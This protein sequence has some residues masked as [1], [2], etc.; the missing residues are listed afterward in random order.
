M[1]KKFE[2]LLD[3]LVNEEM[4]KASQLFH[5][6]VVEKSRDIYESLIA[7]DEDSDMEE[8]F[9]SMA[10]GDESDDLVNDVE[11]DHPSNFEFGMGDQGSDEGD[12]IDGDFGDDD[13]FGTDGSSPATKDDVSDLSDALE[14]LKAE[15]QAL[16]AG[17]KH[18]E[19]GEPDVHGGEL[20]GM[21]DD[22]GDFGSDEGDDID[23]PFDDEG[24]EDEGDEDDEDAEE[25]AATEAFMREYREIVGKPYSGGKVA[26][27]SEESNT[28]SRSV[29]STAKGRPTTSATAGNLLQ[30]TKGADNKPGAGGLVG[31][32]KGEF[33]GNHLNKVGGFK[34]DAFKK[35]T[36]GHGAD[37]KGTGEKSTNSKSLVDRKF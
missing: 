23:E 1:S 9:G 3:Y 27:K 4:D 28:N 35:D 37:K 13:S 33:T 26:G 15:F 31:K 29:V 10:G 14:E 11:D 5:E 25:K 20:D 19:E 2:K 34:G 21:G 16:L 36:S 30:A 32:V 24:D 8:A 22:D 18:E 7:A 17:E 12:D 6:I